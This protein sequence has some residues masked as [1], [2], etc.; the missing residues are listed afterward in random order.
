MLSEIGVTQ[1]NAILGTPAY[2]APEQTEGREADARTDLFALG[3]VLYQ[4]VA[5]KLPFPGASLGNMLAGGKETLIPPPCKVNTRI[6]SRLNSLILRLLEK[7]P[8]HRPQSALSV[9]QELIELAQHT[10]VKPAVMAALAAGLVLA[11]ISLWW[12]YHQR[13][14]ARRWGE[15]S[16]VSMI[17]QYSGNEAT[18][19]VS[20][21]GTWVAFSWN[22]ENGGHQNIYVTRVDGQEEPRQL[23]LDESEDAIDVFPAW[24][25]DARQFAFVRK[26]GATGG[27]NHLHSREGRTGTQGKGDSL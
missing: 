14:D 6:G 17:T 27:E 1:I 21:D 2:M 8:A 23:T 10:Q 16:R 19:D 20:P 26:R 12:S 9:Q 15:V 24:S 25:H 7:D 4:M 3:L 5:G 13:P 11:A 22:G 18:P